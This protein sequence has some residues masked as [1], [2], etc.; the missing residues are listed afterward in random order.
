MIRFKIKKNFKYFFQ[1]ILIILNIILEFA[2]VLDV[3]VEFANAIMKK[4][5][6]NI[7]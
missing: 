4:N 3:N 7:L 6:K 2:F 1:I 5:V